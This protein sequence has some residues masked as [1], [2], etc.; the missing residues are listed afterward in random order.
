VREH[1]GAIT[2]AVRTLD[3]EQISIDDIAV[4][5]PTL[6]DVFLTLTGHRSEPAAEPEDD[7]GGPE[8]DRREHEAERVG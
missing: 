6:D 5:R 7:E 3:S 4:R 1:R 2:A 8:S